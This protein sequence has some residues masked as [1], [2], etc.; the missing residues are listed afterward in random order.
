MELR[1]NQYKA[2]CRGC[3]GGCVHIL[4]VEDGKVVKVQ[5][6]ED[7][8]LNKG[9]ACTKGISIIEQMYHPDRIIYPMRRTGPRGTGSWERISW[10]EAYDAISEKIGTLIKEHGPECISMLTGTG[11]HHMAH[12]WRFS[13]VL[14]TPNG[15]SAGPLVCLDP[16]VHSGRWTAGAYASVDYFGPTKPRGILV[17]GANPAVSGADGELQWFVKDAV[18]SGT[19]LI[20]VDVQPT[21]LAK[22]AE[23]WLRLRPGTDGALALGI[24]NVIISEE[25]YDKDFVEN[26]TFGFEELRARCAQYGLD[27]VAGITWVPK[28]LIVKAA[29]LIASIKP[30][31]L[32]W[33]CAIEQSMNSIQTCR[34][35]FMMMGITGNYDAPGGFVESQE[36]APPASI[37][38]ERLSPEMKA[39][40]LS[41]GLPHTSKAPMAHPRA[42]LKAMHDGDPYRIRALLVHANNSLLSLPD[43]EYVYESFQKLDFMAYMDFFM[44]PTAELADIFLPAALW[45][46][47]NEVFCMPEFSEAV[48]LCMQKVAQVGECKSDEEVFLALS[49]RM[50]LDY[51]AESLEDI[52]N[53][54]LAEMG[55][56]RPDYAGISFEQFKKIGYIEPKREYYNYKKKG[57]FETPSGKFEL[58]SQTMERVGGDPLPFWHEVSE[59]PVSQPDL[60]KQYPLVL[61][62]GGR[63]H[64]YFISNNRQIKSLRKQAPF[65]QASMH[66]D[67]A[68]RHGIEDG[69]WVFIETPRGKITQKAKLVQE[70]D[71]RVINCE[72]GWW[73]PEAGAP[74]YGWK[75]SNAN[76]LT[77]GEGPYDPCFGSYQ[78]RALL[79]RI[80]KNES[81]DIE[82]RYYESRYYQRLPVDS[83]SNSIVLDPNQCIL[84]G[85]CVE[86]CK[87]TQ[88]VRAIEIATRD[89]ATFVAPR[90]AE[91][92]AESG[93]VGC[94]QCV[95]SCPE[96]GI[97]IKSSLE[98]VKKVL[99]DPDTLVVAQVAPSVRAGVSD[100]FGLPKGQNVMLKLVSGL[101]KIGFDMVHDTTFSADLTIVEEANEFLR[102]LSTGENIPLFTSCCPAWVR[103]CEGR[104][105]ELAAHISTCRSPQQMLGAVQRKNYGTPQSL[106]GRA[107]AAFV[108][109]M[110][111]TAKKDEICR[112]ESST[113]G[114]KD[115]DFVLTTREIIY[116]LKERGIDIK[117]C[118]DGIVDN[119]YSEGSGGGVIFGV[120]GGVTEAVLRYLMPT[121]GQEEIDA[122]ATIGVRGDG[123]IK[124]FEL[125][126]I[127]NHLKIAVAS[128]LSNADSLMRRYK[129]GEHFD[130]I[131]VMACPGGC[132]MGGGQP[133]DI[134]ERSGNLKARTDCLFKTDA[135]S[136]L[137]RA[138]EN[139]QLQD[140]MNT[141]LKGQEHKL[142]HRNFKA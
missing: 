113:D 136:G 62:T 87:R 141:I 83:S 130:F 115:V 137:K 18:K 63:R 96:N 134:Y 102:R 140:A 30:I 98:M 21:E 22:R 109:I 81:R 37:L 45:P 26:W 2:A 80:S 142:L 76:I 38:M 125:D 58:Y 75:E 84:C 90:N 120:T 82:R 132:V 59:S 40:C 67:T 72:M 126:Y 73:Y 85:S 36:V 13:H 89:G 41:G 69:D 121:L 46:E 61:T 3:H 100:A 47:L 49:K 19:P 129:N 8:P 92:M 64:Q 56:R 112:S 135:E 86:T 93:C 110:P 25:L 78:L 27:K 111:C 50:G 99:A 17:W 31:S 7:A 74:D 116:L 127:G 5:P 118:D 29:R 43:S 44:T 11:R 101:R 70:M 57:H 39:K 139:T 9:R 12:F 133:A 122:I 48:I 71:A 79:C 65:P 42:I 77:I 128:G 117:Q 34:A 88:T 24:L 131:E 23:V 51:G 91:S 103:F 119:P 6:D 1:M 55:R 20:V 54:Q 104:Y 14:G 123:K 66:P 95:A 124:E 15:A 52:F 4:T 60:A 28:E 97:R 16:R 105:P 107:K 114:Q 10:D 68:A 94:G 33:G 108:S 106:K 53:E 35:L 138:N 32:E